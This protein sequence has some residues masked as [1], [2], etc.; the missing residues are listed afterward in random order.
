MGIAALLVLLAIAPVLALAPAAPGAV[1][2]SGVSILW[3]Y[4]AIVAP[5]IATTLT[6][7]L[8]VRAHE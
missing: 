1:R 2:V 4:A 5:L 6:I 8:L 3:W 7:V